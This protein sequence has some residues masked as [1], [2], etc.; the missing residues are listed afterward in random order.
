MA[1][2]L[3]ADGPPESE[4]DLALLMARYRPGLRVTAAS[5]DTAR[6]LLTDPPLPGAAR[7]PYALLAAAAVDLLPPWAKAAV[8]ADAPAAARIPP[9]AARAAWP[10]GDPGDPLGAARASPTA[11]DRLRTA[12]SQYSSSG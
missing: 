5:R 12:L 1:R 6:F 10:R 3:G 9:V 8:A 7:L 11:A 4:R 2:A